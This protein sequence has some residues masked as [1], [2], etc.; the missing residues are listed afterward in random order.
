MKENT[1][2]RMLKVLC[3]GLILTAV[4]TAVTLTVSA[5]KDKSEVGFINLDRIQVEMS[6]FEE[7]QEQARSKEIELNTFAQYVQAQFNNNRTRLEKE[8][9]QKKEGKSAD[10]QV[11][12]D[13]EYDELINKANTEKNQKIEA[14]R[15]RLSAELQ[16]EADKLLEELRKIVEKVAAEEGVSVVLE[17]KLVYYGGID[18]TD[19]VI[20]AMKK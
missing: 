9:D 18:L 7:L 15:V 11:V 19:K 12:I 8:R 6:G 16:R 1:R 10:Q 2:S 20:A 4:L 5:A 3:L 14:E 17:E 13:Q